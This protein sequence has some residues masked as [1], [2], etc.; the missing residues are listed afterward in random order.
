MSLFCV[1]KSDS[2]C[3]PSPGGEGGAE[4]AGMRTREDTG[5]RERTGGGRGDGPPVLRRRGEDAGTVLLEDA[6]TVLLSSSRKEGDAYV[7]DK[8]CDIC[9]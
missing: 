6:G 7:S 1:C 5:G 9:T 8:E 2:F 4:D 3:L